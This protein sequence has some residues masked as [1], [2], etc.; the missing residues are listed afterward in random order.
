MFG[1][2]F[3][4]RLAT[5]NFTNDDYLHLSIGQQVLFGA[6]PLR[7]FF[8]HGDPLFYYT[9][10]AFQL[11]LGPNLLSEAVLDALFLSLGYALAFFLSL[12]VT[13]SVTIS[14]FSSI[15]AVLFFPRLYS[16][17]KIFLFVLALAALWTYVDNRR[18]G[19]LGWMAL[20]SALAFLFRHDY[21]L[22]IGGG[23]LS[24][25]VLTHWREGARLV[26]R[27]ALL[28]A[29]S[30]TALLLPF[31]LFV[32]VQTGIIP[33]VRTTLETGQREYERTAGTP[34]SFTFDLEPSPSLA[35]EIN[36]RWALAVPEPA[37]RRSEARYRLTDPVPLGEQTWRYRLH[38]TS[39][40]NVTAIVQDPNIE[41]T[42]NI[43]RDTF[44]V[45][46]AVTPSLARR[47]L[48][49]NA[50][51]WL[52]Y[53]VMAVPVLTLLL[54]VPR[55]WLRPTR[56]GQIGGDD[57]QRNILSLSPTETKIVTAAVLN[58]L[59]N[60]YLLRAAKPFVIPDVSALTAVLGAWLLARSLRGGAF[61]SRSERRAW[62][63]PSSWPWRLG[64]STWALA[65]IT[66]T[67]VVVAITLAALVDGGGGA[68][69]GTFIRGVQQSG[70]SY[71][72]TAAGTLRDSA[73][74]F[75][76]EA[77]RYVFACTEESDRLLVA[78]YAPE[79]YYQS[80]RAFAGGRVYFNSSLGTSQADQTFSLYRLQRES[81]PIVLHATGDDEFALLFRP[82]DE[83]LRRHYRAAGEVDAN[84]VGFTVL[85]D[86]RK[87]PTRTYDTGTLPCFADS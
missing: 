72:V 87:T 85:V 60:G 6:L 55:R 41:D 57:D 62:A 61:R 51:P 45:P 34:P 47:A 80:G 63:W 73:A 2:C 7:D 68:A 71:M 37:R 64:G 19:T 48:R 74:P 50:A 23:A 46:G 59:A 66:S 83:Y 81:V 52:F 69:L 9:S 76:D 15:A 84:N 12:H 78:G 79:L 27:K 54:I 82:I 43:D 49:V 70:V 75:D 5:T 16:Y 36:V 26:L 56:G 11:V 20:A 29:V 77:P 38:D 58:I 31:L 1:G 67:L 21:A 3:I 65:R 4:F 35:P 8:D 25:L 14:A 10:A 53:L 24:M 44:S 18:E 42:Q 33:Y 32:Q 39:T 40:R 86:R 28:Y 22:Y 13:R 30:T 17:P